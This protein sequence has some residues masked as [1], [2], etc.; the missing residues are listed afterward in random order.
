MTDAE[1]IDA[2][3][4]V[5]ERAYCPYSNFS[6]GAALVDSEGKLYVGCNVENAAY[7]QGHCA[8][9]GAIGA[10]VA[11]GGQ[12]IATIAIVGGSESLRSCPPCGGCRQRILEFADKD[13]RII[14]QDDTGEAMTYSI[15]QL[16]PTSFSL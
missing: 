5:R 9:A 7:P 4:A 3:R 12:R 2:A 8:E 10:M 15:E 6:V 14:F 13:T 1:L 16:L 11:A